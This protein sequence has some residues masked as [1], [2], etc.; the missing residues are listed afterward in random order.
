M[1]TIAGCSV[2]CNQGFTVPP[3]FSY[4]YDMQ[5]LIYYVVAGACHALPFLSCEEIFCLLTGIA[6][7]LSIVACIRFIHCLTGIRREWILFA[8]FLLPESVAIGMYPNTA[9]FAMLFFVLALNC[10]LRKQLKQ[11]IAWMC[12]A[13]LFRI[14]ILMVY[15]VILFVF[16]WQKDSFLVA[17]KKS[18]LSAIAIVTV[19]AL[20][21]WLLQANPLS[22]TLQGYEEWNGII[23]IRQNLY[24]IFSFYTALG[25]PLFLGGLYRI[26]KGKDYRLLMIVLAPVALVHVIYGR[27]GCAT[28]HY[29]YM[30]PFVALAMTVFLVYLSNRL[31]AKRTMKYAAV[32]ALA[33]F[34]FVSLRISPRI[35]PWLN[36]T[37]A[38]IGSCLPLWQ[39]SRSPL[40]FSVGIGAGFPLHTADEC[41]LASGNF[42]YP[43]H[44]HLMKK[45]RAEARA[46]AYEHLASLQRYTLLG[47]DWQGRI[48]LLLSYLADGYSL[49]V[50][51]EGLVDKLFVLQSPDGKKEIELKPKEIFKGIEDRA[52]RLKIMKEYI[53]SQSMADAPCYIFS[54]LDWLIYCF[55]QFCEEGLVEKISDGLYLVHPQKGAA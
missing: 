38:Q 6:A 29:L 49:E 45:R 11:A 30:L 55:D 7:A 8:M 54:S 22:H 44:I 20:C 36:Q 19:V 48:Y 50:I 27:M 14:D 15:P 52:D 47:I 34:L 26:L 16:L 42:F 41:M 2:L 51:K 25:F 12:L 5:P 17:L 1:H 24:A 43:F 10:L 53:Q 32:G 46:R 9:I 18:A 4:M 39:E 31:K 33:V 28:K 21:Y 40:R 3:A 13:P 37:E 35:Y 23:A